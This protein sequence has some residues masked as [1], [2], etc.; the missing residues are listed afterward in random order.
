[1]EQEE[2]EKIASACGA[3]PDKGFMDITDHRKVDTSLNLRGTIPVTPRHQTVVNSIIPLLKTA[4]VQATIH[5]L[6]TAYPTRA[7]NTPSGAAAAEWIKGQFEQIAGN[8]DDITVSLFPHPWVQ[9]SVVCVWE[10]KG[11]NKDQVVIVGG[12]EDSTSNGATAPGADDD[13]SGTATVIEIFR[14]LIE[15]GF[16]P[17]R[18]IHFHAYAAEEAGLR[19][20]QAIAEAYRN[21]GVRVSGMLQLDMTGY[22]P[23]NRNTMSV[24]TDFTDATLNAFVRLLI[25]AYTAITNQDS[26]CGYGCSDHASWTRFQYP[27]SFVFETPFGQHN[28]NIHTVRDTLQHISMEHVLEFAKLGVGFAV[29]MSLN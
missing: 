7:Y 9:S 11:H 4:P 8:R 10:G 17:D 25:S 14:V 5:H 18:T 3:N 23:N 22:N 1:M 16:V 12:H 21:N 6:S 13:G 29:E 26:R 24:I 19:G 20:S 28:P 2:V 27:A 15:A